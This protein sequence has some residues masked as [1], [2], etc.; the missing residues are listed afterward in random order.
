[1]MRAAASAVSLCLIPFPLRW[2]IWRPAVAAT[3]NDVE[4]HLAALGQLTAL[5]AGCPSREPRASA[6]VAAAY[7]R[8]TYTR[9]GYVRLQQGL[10]LKCIR[11]PQNAYSRFLRILCIIPADGMSVTSFARTPEVA[12]LLPAEQPSPQQE[13]EVLQQEHQ[14][15]SL[16][17]LQQLQLLQHVKKQRAQEE[18]YNSAARVHQAIVK[19]QQA[20]PKVQAIEAKKTAAVAEEDFVAAATLQRQLHGIVSLL[21][22]AVAAALLLQ[23]DVDPLHFSDEELTEEDLKRCLSA[24]ELAAPAAATP[25]PTAATPAP[26]GAACIAANLL[27]SENFFKAFA[28]ALRAAFAD[29]TL[30]V[31]LVAAQILESLIDELTVPDAYFHSPLFMEVLDNVCLCVTSGFSERAQQLLLRLCVR[32]GLGEPICARGFAFLGASAAAEQQELAALSAEAVTTNTAAFKPDNSRRHGVALRNR[33][34]TSRH[35]S[36]WGAT[37]TAPAVL[38]SLRHWLMGNRSRLVWLGLLQHIVS[39]HGINHATSSRSS[40]TSGGSHLAESHLQTLKVLTSLGSPEVLAP[41]KLPVPH[42]RQQTHNSALPMCLFCLLRSSSLVG[43]GMDEHFSEACPCLALCSHCSTVLEASTM[44]RH[45]L[46]ECAARSL[47]GQC[48]NCLRVKLL[49]ELNTHAHCTP[50]PD[51][52]HGYCMYCD[53][54]LGPQLEVWRHHLLHCCDKNPRNRKHQQQ[55]E[56]SAAVDAGNPEQTNEECAQLQHQKQG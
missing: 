50:P 54:C 3:A 25:V 2:C 56:A 47:Y 43:S 26:E 16:F 36:T 24:S 31:L 27:R 29:K 5:A 15:V 51:T 32:R 1:M 34:F 7:L 53:A 17:L 14:R 41:R 48:P 38:R 30:K 28:I 20:L 11:L 6:R 23:G 22:R 33:L 12:S 42:T 55:G 46:E 37:V 10:Q 9:A 35:L 52:E 19:L 44:G 45:L 49:E 21:R 4:L 13:Q 8:C 40:P 18:M 39:T